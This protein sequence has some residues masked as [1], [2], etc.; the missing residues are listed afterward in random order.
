MQLGDGKLFQLAGEEG[1][2]PARVYLGVGTLE[3]ETPEIQGQ[4]LAW[5]RR[6][7]AILESRWSAS[8]IPSPSS[9][10]RANHP[11]PPR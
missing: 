10:G 4:I 3:G 11:S 2:R 1:G 5:A 7:D 9:S 8:P 6:L